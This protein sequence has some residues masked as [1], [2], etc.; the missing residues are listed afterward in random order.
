MARRRCV[1]TYEDVDAYLETIA[2]VESLAPAE[3]HSGHWPV[4]IGAEV[5]E[6]LGASREFVARLDDVLIERLARPA[7]LAELCAEAERGLGPWDSPTH[8]LMFIVHGHIRRLI[9]ARAVELL[10]PGVR[11]ARYWRGRRAGGEAGAVRGAVYVGGRPA[12]PSIH[13][14]GLYLNVTID[15]G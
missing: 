1:P 11:P 10:E 5:G 14:T 12:P 15:R 3:L 6:F 13:L 4:A 2:R 7:T 9:R 8:M